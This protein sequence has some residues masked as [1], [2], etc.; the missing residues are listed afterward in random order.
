VL[1]VSFC[2]NWDHRLLRNDSQELPQR[3]RLLIL[4]QELRLRRKDIESPQTTVMCRKRWRVLTRSLKMKLHRG[5]RR[6]S[7]RLILAPIVYNRSLSWPERIRDLDKGR[8]LSWSLFL[9]Q[10]F[11]FTKIEWGSGT[12]APPA[13]WGLIASAQ[14]GGARAHLKG[15]AGSGWPQWQSA[16]GRGAWP[17]AVA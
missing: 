10:I 8:E 6:Q 5:L 13:S 3:V 17:G 16:A 15:A 9:V 4:S 1:K 12:C 14:A 2:F 11:N 7:S